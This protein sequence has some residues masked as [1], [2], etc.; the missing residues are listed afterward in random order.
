M[1]KHRFTV[2]ALLGLALGAAAIQSAFADSVVQRTETTTYKGT[3]TSIDPSA[4]TIVVKSET[5][6]APTTY[7]FNKE[8]VFVD[9]S[10]RTVTYDA[11][12]DE[13]VTV[14]VVQD[15]DR[16]IVTRVEA[17]PTTIR[18]DTTTT[19]TTQMH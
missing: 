8:T 10:G 11:I 14:R 12:K 5:A 13:P 17:Q 18:R 2:M 4:S 9:P 15:G 19:T 6:P 3:V 7:T 16:M 1:R